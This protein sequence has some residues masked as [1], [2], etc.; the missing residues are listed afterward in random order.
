MRTKNIIARNNGAEPDFR[1]VRVDNN[2]YKKFHAVC[3]LKN[4][5]MKHTVESL[6]LDWIKVLETQ[7]LDQILGNTENGNG[8]VTKA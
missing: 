6:I 7:T 4:L 1:P 8:K 3:V 2:V 5:C